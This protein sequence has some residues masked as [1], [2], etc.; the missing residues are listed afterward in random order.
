MTT[1]PARLPDQ[2]RFMGDWGGFNLTR[3]CG[4]LAGEAAMRTNLKTRSVIHTGRGMVDNVLAAGRGT[5]DVAVATPAQ[6]AVMAVRGQGPFADEPL[7]GLRALGVLPHQDAML[8]AIRSDLGIR[9]MADLRASRPALRIALSPDDG[10]SFMGLGAASL[11]RASGIDPAEIVEWGGELIER[12]HPNMCID[13]VLSGNADAVIHEAIMTPWWRDLADAVELSYLSLEPDAERR[14][15]QELS[16]TA[17]D[18]P[19]GFLRGMREPVRAIDFRGWLVLTND[20]LDDDVAGT[21][22]SILVET[23]GFFEGQYRHIAVRD[24]PLAY[25]IT[26]QGL[27]AVPIP[28]HRGAERYYASLGVDA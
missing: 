7:P 14:L 11:L 3:I 23:S 5:V 1:N 26:P 9:T 16:M 6:C 15:S 4:W 2:L 28:L 17:V 27:A 13:E 8:F 21:I 10:E 19:A 18:V 12:E 24:S 25:P 20:G 22:A